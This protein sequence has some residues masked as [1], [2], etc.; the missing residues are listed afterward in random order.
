MAGRDEA[1]PLLAGDAPT[2]SQ[3]TSAAF[4][5]V[6]AASTSGVA[7]SMSHPAVDVTFAPG[8]AALMP[9]RTGTT[10]AGSPRPDQGPRRSAWLSP[11]GPMTATLPTSVLNGSV[12]PSFLSSTIERPAT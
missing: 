4:A 6:F 12:G 5:A 11:S 10:V 1:S 2:E 3:V 9:S 8:T 7:Q